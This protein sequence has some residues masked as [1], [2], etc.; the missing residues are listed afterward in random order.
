MS[1]CIYKEIAHNLNKEEVERYY[2][3]HLPKDVCE[4]FGF[5]QIYFYRIFDYLGI[6]RRNASDNTKLQMSIMDVESRT[7]RGQ[8][9]SKSNIGKKVSDETKKKISDTQLGKPKTFKSEES[10]QRSVQTRWKKGQIPYNKGIK[11]IVKQS[12]ET[13]IKRFETFK[14]N[15]SYKKSKPEELYYKELCDKYGEDN[16]VRQYY[17]KD[18]YPFHA[19]FY[20]KSED[21]FIELNLHWT[22]G[23]HPFNQE[24]TNDVITLNEWKEKAKTSKFYMRAIYVWTDLDVRKR[25]C[26]RNNNLNFIEIY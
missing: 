21:L 17:S 23:G 22:H 3:N 4:H 13:A 12:K 15:N 6:K 8:K 16:V 24:D 18:R 2:Q 26:A 10:K 14:Q 20:I 25:E 5:N 7:L 9:I 19:D 11:G 1:R